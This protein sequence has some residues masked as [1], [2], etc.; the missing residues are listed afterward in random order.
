MIAAS[1]HRVISKDHEWVLFWMKSAE[2]SHDVKHTRL[3]QLDR[4]PTTTTA[5]TR[6]HKA[7]FKDFEHGDVNQPLESPPFP[8]LL[9]GL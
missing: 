1:L 4:Q 9:W 5:V 3:T 8:Y 6:E 7:I 2:P